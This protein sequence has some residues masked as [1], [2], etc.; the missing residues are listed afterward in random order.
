MCV[1]VTTARV[2]CSASD[3]ANDGDGDKIECVDGDDEDECGDDDAPDVDEDA[4]GDGCCCGRRYTL[5]TCNV[6]GASG[7]ASKPPSGATRPRRRR[8]LT[9]SSSSSSSSSPSEEF[10]ALHSELLPR[11]PSSRLV[12]RVDC[13]ASALPWEPPFALALALTHA[14]GL[15]APLLCVPDD[16]DESDRDSDGSCNNDCSGVMMEGTSDGEDAPLSLLPLPSLPKPDDDDNAKDGSDEPKA[17]F[18]APPPDDEE[19]D[20]NQ[21]EVPLPL[22]PLPLAL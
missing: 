13:D 6:S 1:G 3:G 22:P 11:P 7:G 15:V 10:S 2:S 21:S 5:Y 16:D 8:S 14:S 12:S 4:S 20:E 9:E 17:E 19:E 18:T